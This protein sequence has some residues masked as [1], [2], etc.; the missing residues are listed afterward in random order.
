ML[1]WLMNIMRA[2]WKE[3][4]DR[5]AVEKGEMCFVDK[6]TLDGYINQLKCYEMAG[7]ETDFEYFDKVCHIPSD[8][9]NMLLDIMKTYDKIPD[10]FKKWDYLL[11]DN[12][13]F[14][15]NEVV[16]SRGAL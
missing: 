3:L 13:T 6:A 1:N 4:N 16:F 10:D 14:I 12:D 8:S 2:K 11:I 7:L 15:F 5:T 9:F